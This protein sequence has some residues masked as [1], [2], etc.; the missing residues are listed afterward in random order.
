M[1][2]CVCVLWGELSVS[3]PSACL[4]TSRAIVIHGY[5]FPPPLFSPNGIQHSHVVTH[6]IMMVIAFI[7]RFESLLKDMTDDTFA[8]HRESLVNQKLELD[9]SLGD[10]ASRHWNEI[11]S[12]RARGA[13]PFFSHVREAAFLQRVEKQDLLAWFQEHILGNG[14]EGAKEG[15]KGA[16][17]DA[18]TDA[19]VGM[20]A[21]SGGRRRMA[22]HVVSSIAT[23]GFSGQP[24]AAGESWTVDLVEK[25]A[26]LSGDALE[27]GGAALP[28]AMD[29][30]A[31]DSVTLGK[32]YADGGAGG[33]VVEE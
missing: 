19:E 16:E 5:P 4:L 14:N 29:H 33:D 8:S 31:P 1:C 15:A 11:A 23:T 24:P 10:E 13:S 25:G 21:S 20:D 28:K 6:T 9:D 12:G 7:H 32:R 30:F 22:I 2:V 27:G 18:E 26:T 3:S 17:T